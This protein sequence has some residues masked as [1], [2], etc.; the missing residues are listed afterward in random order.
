MPKRRETPDTKVSGLYKITQPSGKQSWAFRY[1]H[2]GKSRKLTLGSC[3]PLSLADARKRAMEAAV[4]VADGCGDPA[5]EKKVAARRAQAA[6]PPNDL[7]EHVSAQFIRHYA[8]RHLRP[9]TGQELQRLLEKEIVGPWR[10]RRLSEIGKADIH[11]LLDVIVER[12][13]PVAAN[14]TFGVKSISGPGFGPCQKR[15]PRMAASWFCRCPTPLS[16]F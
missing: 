14:R 3:P 5:G 6:P 12:G 4:K 8:K 10:G 7:L 11:Q 15:G 9:R 1:R 13:S 2:E 16:I